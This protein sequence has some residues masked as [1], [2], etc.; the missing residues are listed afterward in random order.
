MFVNRIAKQTE[1]ENSGKT[2]LLDTLER[3]GA[4]W[5]NKFSVL[6]TFLILVIQW[7]VGSLGALMQDCFLQIFIKASN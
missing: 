3:Y 2:V 4:N 7:L 6:F 1:F 5:E